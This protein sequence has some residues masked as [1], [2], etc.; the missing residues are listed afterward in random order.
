M[1]ERSVDPRG[2]PC[3]LTAVTIQVALGGSGK[4]F[5]KRCYPLTIVPIKKADWKQ[6]LQTPALEE[7]FT[8]DL[9]HGTILPK[10]EAQD[11]STKAE[12]QFLHWLLMHAEKDQDIVTNQGP[13]V[14]AD[15]FWEL[16]MV[17][18]QLKA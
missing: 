2:R 4:L 18:G 1:K 10:L 17:R 15:F 5:D 11:S 16:C 12:Y 3:K 14:I 7:L 9:N 6:A 13:A 8:W